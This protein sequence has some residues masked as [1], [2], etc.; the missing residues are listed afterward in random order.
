MAAVAAA[1]AARRVRTPVRIPAP[2]DPLCTSRVLVM[3][4]L[5]GR[6][7]STITPSEEIGDRWALARALF[8]TL[9]REVTIEGIF[10]ADP[11]PGNVLLLGDGQLGL[12]DFGSVGRIDAGLRAALHPGRAHV[13]R[14]VPDRGRARPVSAAG[15]RRGVPCA[16]DDRGHADPARARIRHPRAAS[17]VR[18]RS[19]RAPAQSR[20][21]APDRHR[22]ARLA[23]PD[24]APAAATLGPDQR[25]ARARTAWRQRPPTRRRGR[26]A[27]R[28]RARAPTGLALRVLVLVFRLDA[29]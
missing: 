4:R 25:L 27:L 19:S 17:R 29:G 8:D 21:A 13:H 24:A 16:G 15:D 7:L 5:D 22:R 2:H 1:A 11:H 26:P 18:D 10:H 28:H 9:L 23:D 20:G 6:A 12:L 3:E 14:S